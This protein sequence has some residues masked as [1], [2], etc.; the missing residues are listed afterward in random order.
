MALESRERAM[1]ERGV[2]P[3]ERERADR[4]GKVE[5]EAHRL[6]RT[7]RGAATASLD[8]GAFLRRMRRAGLL[9]RPRYAAGRDDVVA[10]Y[11]VAKTA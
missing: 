6:E 5:I 3:A 11:S 1:E 8:E 7:V 10:A 2:K 4:E 9:I